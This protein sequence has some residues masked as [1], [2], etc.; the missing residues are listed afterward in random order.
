MAIGIAGQLGSLTFGCQTQVD[1]VSQNVGKESPGRISP[2]APCWGGHYNY[3]RPTP[4]AST[5]S[6]L[7]KELSI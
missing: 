5:V 2:N 1:V 3:R 4:L 7:Q 6:P